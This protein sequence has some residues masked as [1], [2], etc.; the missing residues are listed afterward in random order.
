L[1]RIHLLERKRK[2][3]S[4]G[5]LSISSKLRRTNTF[6]LIGRSVTTWNWLWLGLTKT[7]IE[8]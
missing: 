6:L 3:T 4:G 2:E 1:Q 5:Y 7:T 8:I